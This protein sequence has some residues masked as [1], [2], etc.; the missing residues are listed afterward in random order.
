M[1]YIGL[2]LFILLVVLFQ[3]HRIIEAFAQYASDQA[4]IAAETAKYKP[5]GSNYVAP[6]DGSSPYSVK[7]STGEVTLNGKVVDERF[8]K[9]VMK[10]QFRIN[11]TIPAKGDILDSNARD[12]GDVPDACYNYTWNGNIW[13][14]MG[15]TSTRSSGGSGSGT[16]RSKRSSGGSSSETGTG[17]SSD[18]AS[19]AAE[20]IAITD[21]STFTLKTTSTV[22]EIKKI[23][24]ALDTRIKSI[25]GALTDLPNTVTDIKM[26]DNQIATFGYSKVND[27]NTPGE[28]LI[29]IS[30]TA[31]PVVYLTMVN[32]KDTFLANIKFDNDQLKIGKDAL[33][34]LITE[35]TVELTDT[36]T[37]A[38]NKAYP[39]N[40]SW[41]AGTIANIN[42][43]LAKAILRYAFF[44]SFINKNK[45]IKYETE[46]EEEAEEAEETEE[47]EKTSDMNTNTLW[48]AIGPLG[49]I[50]NAI[51]PG[52]NRRE[53]ASD[54]APADPSS[55]PLFTKEIEERLVKDIL[56]Q[57]KD[58]KIMDRSVEQPLDREDELEGGNCS[59]NAT[60]QG[61]EWRRNRPD[62]SEYIRKD[63]IPCW[64]CS[65]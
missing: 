53:R 45:V 39:D 55:S 30:G 56:T 64:N 61:R 9:G 32:A 40:T 46:K 49:S 34:K 21:L 60:S 63:S 58:Q 1:L 7:C 4:R 11:S 13:G 48:A 43:N 24:N 19:R 31:T 22:S 20:A 6:T 37:V 62:M 27:P 25:T 10:S 44:D 51:P 59:T 15:T 41:L 26:T 2:L 18:L 50:T 8:K 12:I 23:L 65:P 38:A 28:K 33:T 16:T 52:R 3:G 42:T 35:K 14:P 57:L 5:G 47:V 17:S 54:P 36:L 29:K